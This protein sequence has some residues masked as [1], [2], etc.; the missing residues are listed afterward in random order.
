[1]EIDK[2]NIIDSLD[3]YFNNEL[4][5]DEELDLKNQIMQDPE[6]KEQSM[7][8][9]KMAQKI[10]M[11]QQAYE[12]SLYS[13][14]S[15]KKSYWLFSVAA[16][17][18]IMVI[19]DII[20][21]SY[22][23]NQLFQEYY[24][25]YTQDTSNRGVDSLSQKEKEL[26]LAF[27]ELGDKKTESIQVL[28]SYSEAVKSDYELSLYDADIHWYLALAYIKGRHLKDAIRECEYIIEKYPDSSYVS[29]A[30]TL[31]EKIKSIPFI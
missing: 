16:V 30:H 23:T 27:N 3:S 19:I 31:I 6:M 21:K 11:R 5:K 2:N 4:S 20:G 8:L 13:H 12:R 9:A 25:V 1:M 26:F 7:L 24:S 17:L 18:L 14:R 22:M 29:S 28:K 10:R 15:I